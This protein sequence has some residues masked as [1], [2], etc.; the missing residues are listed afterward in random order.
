MWVRAHLRGLRISAVVLA[1]LA[2]VFVEQPT[3]ATILVIA[4]LLLVVL[5]VIEFLG[6]PADTPPI[7]ADVAVPEPA[8]RN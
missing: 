8:S 2:F 3:G 7:D 4:A 6:R 1:V 5:A